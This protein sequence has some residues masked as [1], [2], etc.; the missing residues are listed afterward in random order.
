MYNTIEIPV[1]AIQS[2]RYGVGLLVTA[3]L[4]TAV[5]I[6]TG[7]INKEDK[8]LVVDQNIVIRPLPPQKKKKKSLKPRPHLLRISVSYRHLY[9]F[10]WSILQRRVS[11]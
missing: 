9:Q 3:A 8:R 10:E 4:T 5:V 1:F 7:F 6:E 11:E 2:I